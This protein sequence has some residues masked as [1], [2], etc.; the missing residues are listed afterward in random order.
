MGA[1]LRGITLALVA[2][3]MP[4]ASFGDPIGGVTARRVDGVR[5]RTVEIDLADPRVH[6]GIELARGFPHGS[7]S[8]QSMVARARPT[9][10]IDGAYFSKTDFAPVGDIVVHGRLVYQGLMGTAMAISRDNVVTIRRVIPDRTV[11]WTGYETVLACGPAL[12]L[13]RRIDV[14]PV[15]E[16]FGDP[17]VMGSARR[18]GIALLDERRLAIVE[19]DDPVTFVEWARLMYDYGATDAYNLD[20]G[21]SLALYARGRMLI[22]PGRR[23]TNILTVREEPS[24]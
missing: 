2:I 14:D 20:A 19:T 12:V 17:H 5:I 7:E 9:I 18:M 15:G 24:R 10:A 3:C 16:R 1:L 21:A 13:N 4:G 22:A 8:F 23:L 11:D 6:F